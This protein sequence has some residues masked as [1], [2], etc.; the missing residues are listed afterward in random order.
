M[1]IN[2]V[3]FDYATIALDTCIFCE[4]EEKKIVF[5]WHG[6]DPWD[7]FKICISHMETALLEMRIQDGLKSL[8][9]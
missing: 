7:W 8:G 6:A 3:V 9:D 5:C 1:N 4:D 2:G